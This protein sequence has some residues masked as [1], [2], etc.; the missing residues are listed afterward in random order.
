MALTLAD[1]VA[2]DA[3]NAIVNG[4]NGANPGRIRLYSGARPAGPDTAPSGTLLAEIVLGTVAF[5][6]AASGAA[7][8]DVS[9]PRVT[10]GLADGTTTWWRLLTHVQAIGTGLGLVDGSVTAAGGGGDLIASTTAI[11]T[12]GSVEI[13]GGT[14]TVPLA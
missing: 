14:I 7:T 9:T 11:T 10:T 3:C 2:S 5:G 1:A 8:L 6:T 12:G 4:V 13:T